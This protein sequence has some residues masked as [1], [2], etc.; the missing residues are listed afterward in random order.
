MKPFKLLLAGGREFYD[1]DMFRYK[2]DFLTQNKTNIEII[3][4]GAMGADT[5]AEKYAK[6]KGYPLTVIKADWNTH[7]K[8]AGA[9]RN[10]ELVKLAN[11]AIYFWDGTS[12]GTLDCMKKAKAKDIPMKVVRYDNL[13]LT[14][15]IGF[16]KYFPR[17]AYK[18]YNN[19]P[20][21]CL[22]H[23]DSWVASFE[24]RG[25]KVIHIDYKFDKEGYIN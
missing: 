14:A 13:P 21:K 22:K 10:A 23:L 18:N 5:L 19:K 3:S 24:K 9:I 17:E 7:A 6:E 25:L 15:N 20:L 4:G 12:R 2:V 8:A 11:A 1:Y 16:K